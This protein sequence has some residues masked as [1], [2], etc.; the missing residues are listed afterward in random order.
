[1]THRGPRNTLKQ[2]L[3]SCYGSDGIRNLGVL[4]GSRPRTQRAWW[5]LTNSAH[6]IS[7]GSLSTTFRSRRGTYSQQLVC[8]TC[9]WKWLSTLAEFCG[10]RDSQVQYWRQLRWTQGISIRLVLTFSSTKTIPRDSQTVKTMSLTKHDLM[11]CVGNE[12]IKPCPGQRVVGGHRLSARLAKDDDMHEW[13]SEKAM[14]PVELERSCEATQFQFHWIWD[15]LDSNL[16][17]SLQLVRW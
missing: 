2:W 4:R 16:E 1:M 6:K 14:D 8:E 11:R 3:S 13:K 7:N 12:K 10:K 5:A 15:R 17:R 9:K